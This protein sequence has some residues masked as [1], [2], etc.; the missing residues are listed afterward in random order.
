MPAPWQARPPH[1]SRCNATS[2]ERSYVVP[3]Y[4]LKPLVR[5]DIAYREAKGVK[6]P[7]RVDRLDEALKRL[8]VEQSM[9]VK[10]APPK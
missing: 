1:A 5:F 9:F 2:Y 3:Q 8:D 4:D 7:V 6:A 10:L